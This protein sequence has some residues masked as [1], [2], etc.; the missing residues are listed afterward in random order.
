MLIRHFTPQFKEGT[1]DFSTQSLFST[2]LIN[3]Q[4]QSQTLAQYQGKIL[5]VNFWATWCP[6]CRDEMPELSAF[7]QKYAHKNVVVIGIATDEADAVF[8]M[9]QTSPVAYPIFIQDETNSG[10]QLKIDNDQG[11][12]PYTL[13]I[14]RDGKVIKSFFGRI[15]QELL[16]MA[17]LPLLPQ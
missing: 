11:V 12:L 6:P 3:P 16:E 14:N 10:S 15:N 17:I 8:S 9:L 4:G 5:V 13:I 1:H 7:H 2:N